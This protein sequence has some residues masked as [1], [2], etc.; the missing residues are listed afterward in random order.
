MNRFDKHPLI[1]EY[2]SA[3]CGRVKARE[4]HK[5]IRQEMAGHLEELMSAK[6]EE[7][8]DEKAAA[9]WAIRQMGDP[10][11]VGRELNKVH[12]PRIPWGL[13]GWVAVLLIISLVAMYA[14]ELAYTGNEGNTAPS[15]HFLVKKAMFIAAGLLAMTAFLFFDYRKLQHY[16]WAMY[17]GTLLVAL[18]T[19]AWGLQVNGT[20][21]WIVIGPMTVDW[22]SVSPFLFIVA[23][24][25]LLRHWGTDLRSLAL[26]HLLFVFIP[27]VVYVMAPSVSSLL[28]YAAAYLLLL[29]TARQSRLAIASQ[30]IVLAAMG[31]LYTLS[32]L[33]SRISLGAFFDRYEDPVEGYMYIQIDS[34][35][36]SAGWWGHGFAAVNTKL[37]YIYSDTLFTYLIY[38]MGWLGG[39][40]VVTCAVWFAIHL[41]RM[42]AVVRDGYGKLLISGV[43]GLFIVQYIWSIGMSVGLLPILGGV[44]LPFVSYGGTHL[45][46]E[47]AAMG[48][49]LSVYRRKDMI[50]IPQ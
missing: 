25:G 16:S 47:L 10:E 20:K 40:V 45:I 21:S 12:K 48:I 23:A 28:I 31:G 29:Y 49:L 18:A 4:L 42:L 14:V 11:A 6:Q 24:A 19:M 41:L 5:E 46:V 32:S 35:V 15:G 13:V 8:L 27:A 36:R 26:Q 43:S 17:A 33:H 38:S 9:Q 22:M 3:V 39:G 1:N 50:R 44:T 34:A 30:A 2:L 37:P 7:G